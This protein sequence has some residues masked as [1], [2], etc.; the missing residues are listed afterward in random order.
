MNLFAKSALNSV[1]PFQDLYCVFQFKGASEI[2]SYLGSLVIGFSIES[3]TLES[4]LVA[5]LVLFFLTK[6][7]IIYFKV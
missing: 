1:N 5:S 6:S 3:W 7:L 4:C 2:G